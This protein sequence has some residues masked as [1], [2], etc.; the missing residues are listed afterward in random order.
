MYLFDL[1]RS[2]IPRQNPIG[3]GAADFI[4]LAWL[5]LL[6]LGTMAWRPWI[7]PGVRALARRRALCMVLLAALPVALRLLL[8]PNHPVPAPQVYDEASHLL[9]ADTLRHFR[10]ANPPHPLNQFFETAFT[11]QEPHYASIYPLGQGLLLAA[12]RAV[13]G[14]PWIAVVLVTALFCS[15]TYWMLCAWIAPEWALLGGLLAVI[16]FG[17]LC[18]WMNSYWGGSLAGVAGCL[19]FGSLPRLRGTCLSAK[20]RG[21]DA[22]LLGLGLGVHWLT[23][24]FETLF[25]CVGVML[26]FVPFLWTTR[27]RLSYREARK[28][29][30]AW[31]SISRAALLATWMAL[32]AIALSLLQNR[33]VTGEWFKIPEMLS[34]EQYGV[35]AAL[36]FLPDPVP[37]RALTPDQDSEYHIQ[38]AFKGAP[39]ETLRSYL[40]RLKFNV[41]FYRFYFLPPLY[42]VLPLFFTVLT[43]WSMVWLLLTL[44]V[45]ALGTNFFPAFH[46]HYLGGITCL[47][48]LVSV[49][50]IRRLWRFAPRGV[51]AG[52]DAARLVI[53]FCAAHFVFWYGTHLFDATE[54][55]QSLRP[56]ES[57]IG[58]WMQIDQP[59]PDAHETV[60]AELDAMPGKK[61]VF[62]R[63]FR[64][65]HLFENEFVYNEAD[66]DGARIVWARD[67]G[68]VENEKLV[69]Y[70]PD[71]KIWM[72]EPEFHPPR[73]SKYQKAAPQVDTW[74][75]VT[76]SA[77]AP[78]HKVPKMQLLPVPEAK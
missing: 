22:L 56:F 43:E 41:R 8:L 17:P 76:P 66:I 31:L 18:Y 21:R 64:P 50:A 42:L 51:P 60:R 33:S 48:L 47:L 53:L 54:V 67:L 45:F 39:V 68:S 55:A 62:V 77:P 13:F 52:R 27:P 57:P 72:L 25:L 75:V 38:M 4:E 37:H 69:R 74:E 26:Y 12:G 2:F 1:F 44:V 40:V 58:W 11:L 35:P 61:L 19:V 32:P 63:Y 7:E 16:E 70:Y 46:Y 5:L 71:R 14:S 9:V 24:P 59:H 73:L 65:R 29:P 23:R 49:T 6:L 78:A 3:F 28:V 20:G 15:L 30:D 10:L 34:Q 36:T